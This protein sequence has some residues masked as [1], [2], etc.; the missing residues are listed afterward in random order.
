MSS[1]RS[2]E[3]KQGE[4]EA[5]EEEAEYEDDEEN[6]GGKAGMG[7][8]TKAGEEQNLGRFVY[9]GPDLKL[10]LLYAPAPAGATGAGA[11]AEAEAEA[12]WSRG[13]VFESRLV[14]VKGPTD[15]LAEKQLLWLRLLGPEPEPSEEHNTEAGTGAGVSHCSV[16]CRIVE[17]FSRSKA[18]QAKKRPSSALGP[19]LSSSD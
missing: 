11:G 13:Y 17:T 3:E 1:T 15:V 6:E 2:E 18:K 4:A 14:E 19:A 7:A 16:L 12:D 10:P 8:R 5:A 9:K